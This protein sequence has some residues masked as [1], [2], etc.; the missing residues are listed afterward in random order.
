MKNSRQAIPSS[1]MEV[2]ENTYNMQF[3]VGDA[4]DF[5][6]NEGKN[7]LSGTVLKKY[8]NSCLVDISQ[9]SRLTK[10]EIDQYNQK[11]VVNYK[12]IKGVVHDE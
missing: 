6:F 7:A 9:D 4:V 1:I 3:I 2:R 8:T 5:L 12:K 11:V 10:D